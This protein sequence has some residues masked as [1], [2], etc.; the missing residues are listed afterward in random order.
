MVLSKYDNQKA[1]IHADGNNGLG[2]S[3]IPSWAHTNSTTPSGD[4]SQFS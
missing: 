4:I 3:L 2:T 1:K